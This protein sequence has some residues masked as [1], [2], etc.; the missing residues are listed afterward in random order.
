MEHEF[1]VLCLK[2]CRMYRMEKENRHIISNEPDETVLL[3]Y[4]SE[5]AS[6]EERIRVDDWLRDDEDRENVLLQLAA[7]DHA[8]RTKERI[9]SRNPLDAFSKVKRR[10]KLSQRKYWIDRAYLAAACF[11][12]VLILSTAISYWTQKGIGGETQIVTVQA[13]AGMRTHFNLP[14]GT[15]AYLNSGS[16]L[17]YP[18]H[19]D[20]KERRVT[21]T[22]EAYFKVTHNPEQP[23][24]V[25]VA[26]DRMR[27][28][29]L[30][31]EFNLQSY[32]NEN[33]V[34][35]TLVSGSVNIEA[36]RKGDIVS[37]IKLKPSE[38]AVYDISSGSVSIASVNTEYDTAWKEGRLMFK[39]MP[40]PQ[41]LKKLSYF[42]NVRFDVKDS[43]IN[44]YRFTGTFEN[45]LL[46]QILDYLKISS[47]IDYTIKQMTS[48]DSSGIQNET[49][50]LKKMR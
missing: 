34:Q 35:T 19:Y 23:F 45:K 13:N 26:N 40:I 14:D 4:I 2:F 41:V 9:A 18:L 47:Q 6:K 8:L 10:I 28:K 1:R 46:S 33:I 49:V 50:I 17:S 30:G 20:K 43:V 15:V 37:N 31:T 24:I 32:K 5:T 3:K 11:L 12:G 36:V 27:V 38:R 7:I 21:L 42:Y 25:S 16:V 44:T 48:D 39:D 22:G 29:V